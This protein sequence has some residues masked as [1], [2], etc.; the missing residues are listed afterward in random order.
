M[1]SGFDKTPVRESPEEE[2]IHSAKDN[3]RG[4]GVHCNLRNS[5]ALEGCSS[6]MIIGGGA[7]GVFSVGDCVE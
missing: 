7:A 2:L 3:G 5:L 1:E 6:W 4:S